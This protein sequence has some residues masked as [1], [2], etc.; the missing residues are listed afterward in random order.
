MSLKVELK[1]YQQEHISYVLI[2][3]ISDDVT[4]KRFIDF[5]RGKQVPII[6]GQSKDNTAYAHDYKE[7]CSKN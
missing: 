6:S 7:F 4:R 1:I 3:D 2:S 5:M